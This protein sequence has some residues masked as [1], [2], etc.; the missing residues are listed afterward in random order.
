MSIRDFLNRFLK[1]ES[2]PERR[3]TE[4]IY[5]GDQVEGTLRDLSEEKAH[6]MEVRDVSTQGVRVA[7]EKTFPSG[8]LVEL[9]ILVPDIF[10]GEP[11]IRVQAK[12]IHA[13][14]LEEQR[15]YRI[16]CQFVHPDAAARD[17]IKKLISWIKARPI[18]D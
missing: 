1:G 7:C 5:A 14:K 12:V 13:Y 16:G 3:T 8:T 15:R 6:E 4:R 9:K 18:R 17:R 2:V 11:V 10:Q